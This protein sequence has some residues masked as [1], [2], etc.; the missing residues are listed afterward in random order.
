ME[1]LDKKTKTRTKTSRKAV[2][3]LGK[4]QKL[5]TVSLTSYQN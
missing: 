1:E 3:K 4:I 5:L 2:E